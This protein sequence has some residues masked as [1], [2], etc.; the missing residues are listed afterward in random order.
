MNKLEKVPG[1]KPAEGKLRFHATM[2][3]QVIQSAKWTAIEEF[4]T[5]SVSL[6]T[7]TSDVAAEGVSKTVAEI[8]LGR[9]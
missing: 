6:E 2:D 3:P 5:A 7:A 8:F 9:T 1:R 4:T